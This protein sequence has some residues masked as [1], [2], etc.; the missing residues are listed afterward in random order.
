[1]KQTA[2]VAVLIALLT[3]YGLRLHRLGDE[4]LWYDE[5]V[6]AHLA[7]ETIPQ[8]IAHT[9]RDIHPPG[10]YLLLHLWQRL[11]QPTPAF[12]LEFLY[13]WPS[14]FWGMVLMA[15]IYALGRRLFDGKVATLGVILAAAHPYHLWYSQEVRMYTLGAA[16]GLL[17][18]WLGWN[19]LEHPRSTK[20]LLGYA[21]T[22]ASGMY[23]LYYFAFLL[24][25]VNLYVL[26]RAWRQASDRDIRGR[27]ARL[28]PWLAANLVALILWA[29]WLPVFVRQALEPP[30]PPWRVWPGWRVV[31][32]ESLA[33]LWMGQ[34]FPGGEDG[35]WFWGV[36]GGLGVGAAFYGYA[37][38][39][40]SSPHSPSPRA[41]PGSPLALL[42][43]AIFGPLLLLGLLSVALI[44]LYHVRYFFVYGASSP[45]LLALAT[46]SALPHA[47]PSI[48]Y[49][50]TRYLPILLA[51]TGIL[52]LQ[53]W[54][55][56][57]FWTAPL[58][59][60][61]DHRGAV[62]RLA[63]EWRARDGILVNAGWTY[64][65]AELYWPQ[66]YTS[67]DTSLP[68]PLQRRR[69]LDA[70]PEDGQ[71]PELQVPLLA[72]GNVDGPPSL[73]WGLPE[74]DFYAMPWPAAAEALSRASQDHPRLWHYR[75]YDTVSD[76]QGQV[77]RWLATHLR[78][79][80]DA[81][82][83]GRDFGRLQRFVQPAPACPSPTEPDRPEIL[84]GQ[85]L[86]LVG[87]TLHNPPVAGRTLYV[88]LCWQ[89]R[90][91]GGNAPLR[92]SLRLYPAQADPWEPP[93]SQQ[94]EDLIV[95]ARPSA[96]GDF[97]GPLALP[98]PVGLPPGPY[99]L[100]LV[101]YRGDTGDP[102]PPDAKETAPGG[103]W[104]LA[105]LDVA[106]P[107]EPP[108]LARPPRALFDYMELL[109]AQ[110]GPATVQAGGTVGMVLGWRPRPNPYRDTYR[111]LLVLVDR[112]GRE[113]FTWRGP[114]ASPRYPSGAWPAG[115]PVR[116]RLSFQIPAELAPGV[117]TVELGM[118]RASDGR[119]IPARRWWLPWPAQD[120]VV[121]GQIRVE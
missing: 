51:A 14:V 61:D 26:V 87:V 56:V 74:S 111:A 23:V 62:A 31:W 120:T 49:P 83:P 2:R 80:L 76:P 104:L 117:Y 88:T 30:V 5:T 29:P 97:P 18:L 25:P 69:L 68:P 42:L 108:L 8:L 12:G 63:Q 55:L 52:A 59:R 113:A 94:D 4:S 21:L 11:V 43:T 45:L 109:D 47:A 84:F 115:Y 118:E 17:V 27:M 40:R 3:G 34:S 85:D 101:V 119:R 37:K 77:R 54:S 38:S 116:G 114:L 95:P 66:E 112:T 44:P 75:F 106:L 93:A 107:P 86:A 79:T 99:R 1:M 91:T 15:L 36:L 41:H 32:A 64:T 53:G 65:A 96:R 121:I 57:R 92:T 39:R 110:V 81:P 35:L 33:A 19:W 50:W 22:A 7:Q 72:T 67:T 98:V 6:S 100:E 71:S 10:Y 102:L 82:I 105:E 24:I 28:L 48:R 16:L 58:Y 90:R 60:A 9:A 73:G 103:R 78:Q 20:S 46:R 13:A 70:K 89:E